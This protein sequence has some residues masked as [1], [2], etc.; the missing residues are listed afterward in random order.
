M[1]GCTIAPPA[2]AITSKMIPKISQSMR[3]EIRSRG[4]KSP[5]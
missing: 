4:Y 1:I 5:V 2:I 3:Q